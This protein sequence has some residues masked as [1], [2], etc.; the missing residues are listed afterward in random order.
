MLPEPFDYAPG[1][2]SLVSHKPFEVSGAWWPA[3]L[4]VF[5]DFA[6]HAYVCG[7]AAAVHEALHALCVEHGITVPLSALIE[8]RAH[9]SFGAL[10]VLAHADALLVTYLHLPEITDD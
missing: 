6:R 3:H 4:P 10:R 9:Y 2:F 8:L 1:A 7:E 5:C